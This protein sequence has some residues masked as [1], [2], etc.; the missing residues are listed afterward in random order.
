MLVFDGSW[1]V[2]K[3]EIK[4]KIPPHASVKVRYSSTKQIQV[5]GVRSGKKIPLEIGLQGQFKAKAKGFEEV[6]IRGTGE[7]EFGYS[8]DIQERQLGEPLND[9]DPPAIPLKQPDNLVQAIMRQ[10]NEFNRQFR[11]ARL[12]P[13]DLPGAN[14]HMIDDDDW[15]FEEE[16]VARHSSSQQKEEQEPP[17]RS[18]DMSDSPSDNSPEDGARADPDG[19][20]GTLAAE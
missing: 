14:R 16:L 20:S 7:T 11:H 9:D 18:L 19:T 15:D 13:E 5:L 8:V 2:G 12:E 1:N 17:V 4:V 10:A 3:R 6:I